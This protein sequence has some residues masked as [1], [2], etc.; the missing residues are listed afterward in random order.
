M[1]ESV[2]LRNYRSEEGVSR[3]TLLK[4]IIMKEFL[5]KHRQILVP[6]AAVI[7]VVQVLVR[8][9]RRKGCVDRKIDF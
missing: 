9:T 5:G 6:A 3:K 7:R 4:K 1:Y 8:L 2:T